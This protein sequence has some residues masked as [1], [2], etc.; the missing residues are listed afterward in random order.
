MI[1]WHDNLWDIIIHQYITQCHRI[2]CPVRHK[3][4]YT[5]RNCCHYHQTPT[6]LFKL[7]FQFDCNIFFLRNHTEMKTKSHCYL[8]TFGVIKKWNLTLFLRLHI[9]LR[10]NEYTNSKFSKFLDFVF[11]FP[12]EIWLTHHT[13]HAA[14][15]GMTMHLTGTFVIRVS[16]QPQSGQCNSQHPN[17]MLGTAFNLNRIL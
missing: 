6:S 3:M 5:A 12:F 2:D 14:E 1:P 10:V 8:I 17:E 11:S 7:Y 13:K 4:S 16:R 15:T 9:C